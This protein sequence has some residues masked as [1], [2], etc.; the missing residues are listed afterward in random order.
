[1]NAVREGRRKEGASARE[2]EAAWARR[3]G[4]PPR[5]QVRRGSRSD[6]RGWV[7]A[8]RVGGARHLGRELQAPAARTSKSGGGSA[9]LG[10]ARNWDGLRIRQSEVRACG[11]SIRL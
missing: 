6:S 9:T 3:A 1:M 10:G 5:G 7:S 2:P 11:R 4:A 8:T